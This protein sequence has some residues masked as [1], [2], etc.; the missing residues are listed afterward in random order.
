MRVNGAAINAS[1]LNVAGALFPQLLAGDS[2]GVVASECDAIR[3]ALSG[4]S[5][6]AQ[7]VGDF[8]ASAERFF[9]ASLINGVL[10][11][12]A[13]SA[14]RV[15]TGTGVVQVG[16]SLF[17][18]RIIYGN[19]GAEIQIV[20]ISDVGVVYGEGEGVAIPMALLDG[21]RVRTGFGDSFALTAGELAPSAIRV[22]YTADGVPL[23]PWF[24]ALDTATITS[25][26]IRR[27]DGS[28]ECIAYLEIEDNGFKRQVFIGSLDVEPI[29]DGFATAVRNATGAAV[30]TTDFSAT[31]DTQ[32]LAQGTATVVG[33]AAL[34]GDV[35]V[36]GEGTAVVQVV[37]TLTGYAFRRGSVLNA[38]STLATEL[39]GRRARVGLGDAPLVAIM[40]V[41]GVKTVLGEFAPLETLLYGE[42]FATDFDITGLDDDEEL[43]YRPAGVRELLKPAY[44][45]ELRRA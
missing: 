42:S 35:F 4:G 43:F 3:Y 16:G 1:R 13:A 33:D 40:Q 41:D 10:S 6:V 38:I 44:T 37:A 23:V 19:G 36:R 25:G 29:A 32:R 14:I 18:T 45:R 31:F 17:Y 9:G 20:A 12:I 5:A 39:D 8:T 26:G 30:I 11:D 27:I 22:P 24:G 7:S 28:G 2:V 21:S 15:G 34:A